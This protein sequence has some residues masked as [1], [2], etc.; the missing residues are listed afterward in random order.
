MKF[1][2]TSVSLSFAFFAMTMASTSFA[3]IDDMSEQ[4]D[5]YQ[6]IEREFGQ[7]YEHIGQREADRVISGNGLSVTGGL[8]S[9]GFSYKKPFLNFS[10]NL[11]RNLAPDL[12]D[13]RR[14][15]VT[16]NF[17][18]DIDASKLFG[19]LR[20]QKVIDMTDESM[21]AF[22]GIMFKRKFTWVH[23]ADSYQ[24]GLTRDFDK[25]FLPFRKLDYKAISKLNANEMIF[26][27][28]SISV[29]AGGMVAAPLY[30]GITGMAGVLAKFQRLSRVEIV[31]FPGKTAALNDIQITTEKEKIASAGVSLAVQA[32]F[33]RILRLTL[34]SYD[35]TYDL[36]SSY[37]IYL[38]VKQNQLQSFSPDDLVAVQINEVLKNR[39]GNL[40]V[41][42]PYIISE[43][44]KVAQVTNHKYNF[45]LLGGKKSAKT[46]HIEIVK[47]GKVKTFFRHYFEKIK[48]TEDLASRLF[49][50]VI[51]AL[52]QTDISA[53]KRAVDTKRVTIEYDSEENLLEKQDEI[54]IA[55]TTLN[56]QKLSLTF[57]SEFVTQKVSGAAG[58]KYRE[59][60]RFILERFSGVNPIALKMM[61]NNQL[62]APFNV[63][64]K[65]QVNIDGI[66][67]FNNLS[68]SDVFKY[69]DGLCDE[70][71]SKSF[72]SFRNLFDNCRKGLQNDYTDYREDL[73]H[74]KISADD[75][76]YCEKEAKKKN[77]SSSKTKAYIK[78]CLSEINKLDSSQWVN[79]PLWPLKNLTSNIVYSSYSKVHF[80]NLFG[81]QNVFFF[82]SFDAVTSDGLAFTTSF[83]EGAFKGLGAVDH[84][85]RMENLRAPASVVVDQ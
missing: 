78:L 55:P 61:D 74:D 72:F 83:H 34:L 82:G 70:Y 19:N 44:K 71:P 77:Y 3:A 1:I 20:D 23:Y 69:I 76:T 16:D 31:S 52:T 47:D 15:I 13:D 51:Y 4:A 84:Y 60:A 10:V 73:I 26:K 41:L 48:Y 38:N 39:E 40:K 37:K 57:S 79:I 54:N 85:M 49:A 11:E 2:K 24:E 6:Q 32:D 43:E 68:V 66:R 18:I 27:E 35:F 17:T 25:L 81:V 21:A 62:V 63:E 33:L 7:E 67:Y 46:Q 8:N 36:Q 58:K 42:A 53:T 14:W 5:L 56:E 29:K 80:Y 45:L 9:V 12:F 65:Y 28:D 30:P 59:R 50:S 64:G 22:A 75:I